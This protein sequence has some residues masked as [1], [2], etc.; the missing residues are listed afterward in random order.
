MSSIAV[1]TGTISRATYRTQPP[2]SNRD[3]IAAWERATD[4]ESEESLR[5][6]VAG[7]RALREM[8]ERWASRD[9]SMV[10]V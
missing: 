6:Q 10:A 1:S 7:I 8:R 3:R 5:R 9:K 4:R 2:A